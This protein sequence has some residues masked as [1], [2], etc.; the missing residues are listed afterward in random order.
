MTLRARLLVLFSGSLI[1]LALGAWWGVHRLTAELSAELNT[2]AMS[3]GKSVVAVFSNGPAASP[4][5]ALEQLP[6]ELRARIE[7]LHPDAEGNQERRR[8]TWVWRGKASS[9]SDQVPERV[10]HLERMIERLEQ[11]SAEPGDTTAGAA[12]DGAPPVVGASEALELV[13]ES[14]GGLG[15]QLRLVDRD[16]V[17]RRIPIPSGGVESAIERYSR[18]LLT[19][20]LGLLLLVLLGTALVVHRTTAPLARLASVAQRLGEG[21]LGERIGPVAG[22]GSEVTTAIEAFDRMS[23]RLA[24][25]DAEARQLREREHLGELGEVA[26]AVAHSLRNPLNALGLSVDRWARE[27]SS[28][29]AAELARGAR[30]QIRRLDAS[31]RS[32]LALAADRGGE[33]GTA[34]EVVDL[35]RLCRDVALEAAQDDAGRVGVA[36]EVEGRPMLAG[37]VAAELR[38]IVQ[39][40]V[41]NALEASPDGA[42]VRVAAHQADDDSVIVEVEDRGTGIAAELRPRLFAPH[43]T[44]KPTGSGMGLFIAQRLASSR[45]GGRVELLDREGGGTIARLT[46]GGGRLG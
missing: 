39:A 44:T 35:G 41:V 1:L 7:Q 43:V 25:L 13:L 45:Y 29:E 18:R 30:Q 20:A 32:I 42:T 11:S 36:V 28:P 31:I 15:P 26:R 23:V 33:A 5:A 4:E 37:A 16:R 40:L 46:L 9:D 22:A 6:A 38:S 17:V 27:G 14:H 10:I 21:E 3:V 24:E 8:E 12:P 2:V 19:G 34:G